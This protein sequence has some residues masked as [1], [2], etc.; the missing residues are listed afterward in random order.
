MTITTTA[1][2]IVDDFTT[3]TSASYTSAANDGG[4]PG[5]WNFDTA[6]ARVIESGGNDAAFTYTGLSYTNG[7][8]EVVSDQ[9]DNASIVFRR[10]DNN[11]TY[12]CYFNDNSSTTNTSL[13]YLYVIQN[14]GYAQVG[15]TVTINFSRGTTHTIRLMVCYRSAAVFF[16][17]QLI[18]LGNFSGDLANGT[19]GIGGAANASHFQK[20]T[21][22]NLEAAPLNPLHKPT[23]GFGIYEYFNIANPTALTRLQTI[24]AGGFKLVL[25]YSLLGEEG[26]GTPHISDV[27]AYINYAASLGMKVIVPLKG[28]DIWQTPAIAADYP[29]LYS[30][31]GNQS[32]T[33]GFDQYIVNQTKN[34]T[35]TW[36]YYV[37]DE[38]NN[39]DHTALHNHYGYIKTASPSL[40]VLCIQSGHTGSTNFAGFNTL[41][42]DSC[43]VGGDDY[44]PLGDTAGDFTTVSLTNNINAFCQYKNIQQA[45]VLQAW[46]Q[47]GLA[48]SLSDMQG[49]LQVVETYMQPRL[50]LWYSY[51]DLLNASNPTQLW[52]NLITAI[53][54]QQPHY[55]N[56][57][58]VTRDMQATWKTRG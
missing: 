48:P 3:N 49:W 50:I 40:P 13:V 35:G 28:L 33:S 32:T 6:N 45:V 41:S 17:G 8:V 2:S 7:Y 36:G 30:D 16:D 23:D 58:W 27:I 20:L 31:S 12:I 38:P 9:A 21:I 54:G 52:N 26:N 18:S 5:T 39:S 19:A 1:Y 56:A 10:S 53:G 42:Y 57:T 4:G 25:N 51:F 55:L 37:A 44:Y 46:Q 15:P 22:V 24:A 43:D 34:L 14:G 47:N 11:N 29:N